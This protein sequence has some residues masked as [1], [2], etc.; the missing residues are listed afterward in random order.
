[1]HHKGVYNYYNVKLVLQMQVLTR[2]VC[3]ESLNCYI[4]KFF[5]S[6]MHKIITVLYTE[7]LCLSITVC[8]SKLRLYS[9]A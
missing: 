2:H 3:L 8:L 9:N 5:N 4:V 7:C 6:I 1:M